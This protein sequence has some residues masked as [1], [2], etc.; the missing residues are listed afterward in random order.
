MTE[1]LACYAARAVK[2]CAA[3]APANAAGVCRRETDCGGTKG[4]THLCAKPPRHSKRGPLVLATTLARDRA[5]TVKPL[6]LCVPSRL[7]AP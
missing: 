2:A 3:D 1:G 6:E 7:S 4:V 5:R